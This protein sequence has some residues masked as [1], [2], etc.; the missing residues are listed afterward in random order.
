[1]FKQL[2]KALGI[3][4]IKSSAYHPESQGALERFHQTLKS[5]IGKYCVENISDW[6]E[7]VPFLMFSIRDHVQETLGFS[8]FELVY[9]YNVRG[10]LELLKDSLLNSEQKEQNILK[11]VLDF[12]NKL[13]ESHEIA[14]NNLIKGQEEMK[15]WYDKGARDRTFKVGDKVLALLPAPTQPLSAKFCGPYTVGKKVS[16]L[17]YIIETPDRKKKNQLC[18]INLLKEFIER[19][20][21]EDVKDE[22]LVSVNCDVSVETNTGEM[23]EQVNVAKE[24]SNILESHLDCVK[25]GEEVTGSNEIDIED[26]MIISSSMKSKNSDLLCNLDNFLSYLD[27]NE[28]SDIKELLL[29]Y[30]VLFPDVPRQTR[31]IFHD[32][33]V[34]GCKPIKQHHYRISPTKEKAL[35]GEINYM[36]ENKIIQP[37]HSPWSS[38]CILVPKPNGTWRFVTDFRKVNKY[39]K[40][41]NFPLP[42]IDDCI[43]KVGNACYISKLDLAKGYWQIPLTEKAKEISAFVTPSGLYQYNVVPFG[44]KNSG[45]TFQRLMNRVVEGLKG[46]VVYVDDICVFSSTWDDHIHQLNELFKR[47]E[48][49]NLSVSLNKCEFGKSS[50]CFLGYKIGHGSVLPLESKIKSILDF[51]EPT[52]VKG[53][54]KFLGVVG[55]YRRFCRNFSIIAEPLTNLLKKNKPFSWTEDCQIAFD[56]I[57]GILLKDPVLKAPDFT[58]P[59]EIAVDASHFGIGSVLLQNY[60]DKKHPVSYYSRKLNKSQINYST[61]E[62]ETLSLILSLHHFRV[63]TDSSKFELTVHTD[64]N[65]L[66]FLNNMKNSNQRLLRWSL[67]LQ[68]FKLKIVHI[69]GRDNIIADLL[70]RKFS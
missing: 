60:A 32:V 69:S 4:H 62:K 59:F 19:K 3:N 26:H 21:D 67:I 20:S 34:E 24:A 38:P 46:T 55:Y 35:E 50:V 58:K 10:P 6:D 2:N 11:Y 68:E 31:K 28:L 7:G 39:T 70:S 42:R 8:P 13:I 61:I 5:M 29:K 45:A 18:H 30:E 27:S 15:L 16:D 56:K 36:L 57:K 48:E 23:Y 17:N 44:M 52:N 14:K 40:D 9:G 47:L 33:D 43:D 22:V 66:V 49:Y 25:Q 37:S 41:D 63:Y 12:K 51:P 1:M 64:H 65:P 54:Q 53:I